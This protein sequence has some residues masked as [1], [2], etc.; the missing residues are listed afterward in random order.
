MSSETLGQ[1]IP[2]RCLAGKLR[3]RLFNGVLYDMDIRISFYTA[4]M[5]AVFYGGFF[6]SLTTF[7]YESLQTMLAGEMVPA[8]LH[9]FMQAAGVG[10]LAWLGMDCARMLGAVF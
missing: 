1:R 9:S 10:C 7:S 6:G 4:K 5:A 3:W 2:L 8:V